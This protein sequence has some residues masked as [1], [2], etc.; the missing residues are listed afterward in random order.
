VATVVLG[1]L[2]IAVLT[3]LLDATDFGLMTMIMTVVGL[4]GIWADLGFSNAIIYRQ[5]ATRD[6]LSTLYWFNMAAGV[7]V[8]GLAV[9]VAPLVVEYYGEPAL[10]GPY[11]WSCLAFLVMP[12]GQQFQMLLQRDLLFRAV[13]VIEVAAA[14]VGLAV[15]VGTALAGSGVYALVWGQ[16]AA[17]TC[18][19]ALLVVVGFRRWR[20]GLH[21]A[22][23]D[24]RGFISFGLYQMG[25]RTVYYFTSNV[26]YLL[27]GRYLGADKL[28][29]YTIAYTLVVQPLLR[30]RSVL[31]RVA[32]PVFARKRDDDGA[33]RR[34]FCELIELVAVVTFPVY[35]GLAALAPLA[36]PVIFG[37]KWAPAAVLVQ[38]LTLM[39]MCKTL[40][41]PAGALFLSKGR[42][43]VSF[44]ENVA[45]AI[46]TFAVLR[47]AVFQGA[48]TVA[49]AE[50]AVDLAFFVVEFYLLRYVI[51]L[52]WGQYARRL[53]RPL[54][55]SA[56]MGLVVWLSYQ[57]V[58]G[59]FARGVV[60]LVLLT[61]EGVVV[62][63]AMWLVIDRAYVGRACRLATGRSEVHA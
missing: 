26:D 59:S 60:P 63:L 48:L 23:R 17:I 52:A 13:G 12:A 8:F 34:G 6:Q 29:M 15:S 1:F 57:L 28:G 44:W 27:I 30:M 45:A 20:P 41:N 18:R 39:G 61:A 19:T 58:R 2:Q 51:G 25:E 33:L 38:A 3:R 56:A 46:V 37:A 47:A 5:D 7:A 10:R 4:A 11:L 16:L 50:S 55:T 40:S 54:A 36:V 31:T 21:V 14:A 49:W 32:F 35:L 62:Y 22:R 9:A 53:V 24:L 42:A 43:D